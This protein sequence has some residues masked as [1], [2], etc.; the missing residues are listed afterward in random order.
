[1][2]EIFKDWSEVVVWGLFFVKTLFTEHPQKKA[3]KKKFILVTI[4]LAVYETILKTF[5]IALKVRLK[6]S[7]LEHK[8]CVE[9]IT[10]CVFLQ[11]SAFQLHKVARLTLMALSPSVRPLLSVSLCA[12]SLQRPLICVN[13]S[14]N[15]LRATQSKLCLPDNCANA[16][17]QSTA[18]VQPA[19]SYSLHTGRSR[20]SR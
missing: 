17:D 8:Q 13:R 10:Q 11:P 19:T 12:L 2:L 14:V 16:L 6:F 3:L 5:N 7:A 9:Y 1:M 20:I 18:Q 4:Y 15:R